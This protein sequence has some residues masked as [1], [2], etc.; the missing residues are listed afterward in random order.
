M[1]LSVYLAAKYPDVQE[2]V[3]KE[4]KLHYDKYNG[5]EIKRMSELHIFRAFVYESLRFGRPVLVTLKRDVID[6][7]GID[8]GK[9]NIPKGATIFGASYAIHTNPKHWEKPN[10]FYL[11][12]FLDDQDK[13]K[14]SEYFSL[15]GHGRRNCVGQSFAIKELYAV[16][17]AILHR[18]KFNVP[19]ERKDNFEIGNIDF[20]RHDPMQ[21]PLSMEIRK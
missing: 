8:L 20:F 14:K 6:A 21:L 19:M 7:N 9:W 10:E 1:E 17:S 3:Y 12:H 16:L 4:L 13:F 15:F 5:F 2:R 18:Y 11:E